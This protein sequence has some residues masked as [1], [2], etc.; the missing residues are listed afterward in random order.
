[1]IID[2]ELEKRADWEKKVGADI[3]GVSPTSYGWNQWPDCMKFYTS[4]KAYSD[5]LA[6]LHRPVLP[7]TGNLAL[8]FDLMTDSFAPQCAQAI[9]FD[10][11]VSL[12]GMNYNF[13][14]QVNYALGG[15]LQLSDAKGNWQDTDFRPGKFLPFVWTP[16]RMVY[17]FDTHLQIYATVEVRIGLQRWKSPTKI[18][19]APLPLNWEDSCSLQIQQDLGSTG[20]AF[21]IYIRNAQYEWS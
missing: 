12:A 1:M 7:N 9:E 21:A 4:G 20:G 17:Q 18:A 10:T 16:I 11:R 5:W 6:A 2:A 14:A 19:L 15:V 8:S 3:G 13:S